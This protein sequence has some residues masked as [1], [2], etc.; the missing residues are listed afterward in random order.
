[1]MTQMIVRATQILAQATDSSQH[2]STLTAFGDRTHAGQ[3]VSQS[4]LIVCCSARNITFS[5]QVAWVA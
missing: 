4:A 3:I 5:L 2:A 1:M